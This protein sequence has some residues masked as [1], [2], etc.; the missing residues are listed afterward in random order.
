MGEREM[1]NLLPGD[2]TAGQNATEGIQRKSYSETEVTD[3]SHDQCHVTQ[4][5]AGLV[6]APGQHLVRCT[7]GRMDGDEHNMESPPLEMELNDDDAVE[8]IEL[9][10]GQDVEGELIQDMSDVELEN[11]DSVEGTEAAA[12]VSVLR[13]DADVVFEK[14]SGAVFCVCIDPMTSQLVA[15]GGEDDKAYVWKASNGEVLLECSDMD[16]EK[17]RVM[18]NKYVMFRTKADKQVDMPKNNVVISKKCQPARKPKRLKR[19]LQQERHSSLLCSSIQGGQRDGPP[20][21]RCLPPAGI[22][23]LTASPPPARPVSE[24]HYSFDYAQQ[25]PPA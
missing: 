6:G 10:D 9:E 4:A 1:D 16:S 18:F 14:H 8:V 12:G 23:E 21:Q 20:C 22:S 17:L 5:G 7:A 15:S 13:D 25:V 2:M 3:V 24:M 19:L 11:D